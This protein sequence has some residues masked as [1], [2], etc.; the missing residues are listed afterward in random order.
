MAP[1]H[2]LQFSD[3]TNT[4]KNA[5]IWDLL[6][7]VEDLDYVSVESIGLSFLVR[8][9]T[10]CFKFA[11]HI[12]IVLS[13][14]HI[15]NFPSCPPPPQT[16]R[17]VG[18]QGRAGKGEKSFDGIF[19][20]FLCQVILRFISFRKINSKKYSFNVG[21]ILWIIFHSLSTQSTAHNR[22]IRPHT[23]Y[24]PTQHYNRRVFTTNVSFKM[25]YVCII[26]Y[27]NVTQQK[28]SQ[29]FTNI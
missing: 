22:H 5:V 9:A 13:Y 23:T 24:K 11:Y 26:Y 4:D 19:P 16:N 21:N 17:Q 29:D 7:A 3:H 12:I 25:F 28:L 8:F 14:L 27:V 2:Q 6:P 15:L 1:H 20:T 10:L 18:H